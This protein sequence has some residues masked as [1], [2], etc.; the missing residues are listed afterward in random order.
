[1]NT[2]E[3]FTAGCPVCE[4]AVQ[5]VKELA[6]PNCEVKV[7]DLREGCATNECRDK[8][9]AYGINRLPA[10]VVNGKIANC[11]QNEPVSREALI[12][13]GVGQG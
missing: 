2:I 13:A 8:A 3:V 1:M 4:P 11:C 10:V 5:L 7:Y 6:C 9:A 12:E